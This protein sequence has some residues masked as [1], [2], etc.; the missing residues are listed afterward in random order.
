MI[1]NKKETEKNFTTRTV[2]FFVLVVFLS[3]PTIRQN[4]RKSTE[5]IHGKMKEKTQKNFI[6][7]Q[8]IS[9]DN[10]IF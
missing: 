8:I 7:W 2:D 4:E 3:S 1:T 9:L 6:F 10:F 5:K